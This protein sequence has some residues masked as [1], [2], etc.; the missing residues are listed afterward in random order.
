MMRTDDTHRSSAPTSSGLPEVRRARKARPR[1]FPFIAA[2]V[3]LMVPT[4]VRA[5]QAVQTQTEVSRKETTMAELA[6]AP[7]QAGADTS[8]RPFTIRIPD[9]QLADLRKRI[10]ATR[11]PDKETVADHSQGVQLATM[12]ELARY[13]GT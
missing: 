5:Q 7:R 13:W 12:K 3:C 11:W 8:I 9:E 2:A 6:T 10:L 4:F 1:S